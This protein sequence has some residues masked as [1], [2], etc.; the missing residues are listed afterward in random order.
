MATA[1]DTL[2]SLQKRVWDRN[3]EEPPHCDHECIAVCPT[4]DVFD[5]DFWGDALGESFA[6]LMEAV[7]SPV[8]A[9]ALRSLTLRGPDEG[10]NGTR[11]WDLTELVGGE[12]E[13][14]RLEAVTI[15]Q[16]GPGDHNRSIVARSYS[17]EGVLAS[18]LAAAPNLR[19]LVSPSAP[20]GEFFRSRNGSLGYLSLDA[21]YDAQDFILNFARK[22][23]FPSLYSLEWGE[24]NETYMDDFEE[25]VTPLEHYTELFR[26]GAFSSLR[27][28]TWR[29]PQVSNADLRALRTLCSSDIQFK[30]VRFASEYVERQPIDQKP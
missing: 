8:V 19:V 5:V 24:Y 28:F 25:H 21:G 2:L 13:F 26:S 30:V 23:C 11:N 4:G 29:N 9:P 7:A 20:S 3:T 18:L 6:E 12:A 1:R 10:A 15:Q 17:E 27:A 16:N 14:P 22:N